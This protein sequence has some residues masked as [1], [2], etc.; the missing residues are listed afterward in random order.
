MNNKAVRA[1]TVC[2]KAHRPQ[3]CDRASATDKTCLQVHETIEEAPCHV[4]SERGQ[5]HLLDIFAA[6]V[7]HADRAGE[8]QDDDQ[9]EP[10]L[11][12]P[13]DGVEDALGTRNGDF[14]QT[15]TRQACLPALNIR[16][17]DWYANSM[18]PLEA[19]L[20]VPEDPVEQRISELTTLHRSSG[21]RRPVE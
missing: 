2:S 9:P 16:A 17:M 7:L 1:L 13:V 18:S 19:L 14:R 4:A 6:S 21:S 12:D 5:N 11:G 3:R 15:S 10:D 8:G 20:K